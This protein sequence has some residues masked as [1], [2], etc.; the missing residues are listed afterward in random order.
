MASILF[1]ANVGALILVVTKES[2]F[3]NGRSSALSTPKK[4]EPISFIFSI[5]I[6]RMDFGIVFQ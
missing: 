1:L 4:S 6:W 5:P 2:S 3:A